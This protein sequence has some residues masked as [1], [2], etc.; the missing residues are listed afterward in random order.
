MSLLLIVLGY[1]GIVLGSVWALIRS[2]TVKTW[3]SRPSQVVV[4]ILVVLEA[5]FMLRSPACVYVPPPGVAAE[6]SIIRRIV[7]ADLEGRVYWLEAERD[8]AF[9]WGIRWWFEFNPHVPPGEGGIE[10]V[11]PLRYATG[12]AKRWRMK[13]SDGW[14]RPYDPPLAPLPGVPGLDLLSISLPFVRPDGTWLVG[15]PSGFH[16]LSPGIGTWLHLPSKPPKVSPMSVI[17]ATAF[18]PDLGFV[19]LHRTRPDPFDETRDQLAVTAVN[20]ETKHELGPFA[21]VL[22][23]KRPEAANRYVLALAAVDDG[24]LLFEAHSERGPGPGTGE[25]FRISRDLQQVRR[26]SH[27]ACDRVER[28]AFSASRDGL[29]FT[30]GESV[31]RSTGERLRDVGRFSSSAWVG[32]TLIGVRP[33][34]YLGE[35]ILR[36]TRPLGEVLDA[37][38]GA[39]HTRGPSDWRGEGDKALFVEVQDALGAAKKG[40]WLL[41]G[42][43]ESGKADEME[44][45]EIR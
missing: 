38:S 4:G 22:P 21:V 7:G 26:L 18:V 23:G 39:E 44:R 27:F 43:D 24:L 12:S 28:L 1:L 2:I 36:R 20:P 30:T 25:A 9:A 11:R 33:Y 13:R 45:I 16:A 14:S 41:G 31:H 32:H 10:Y 5:L 37:V 40:K 35:R 6:P 15:D 8:V 19:H 42:I 29:L 34:P 17:V 3:L